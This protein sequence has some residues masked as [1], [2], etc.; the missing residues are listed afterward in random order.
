MAEAGG[1]VTW[2]FGGGLYVF[3]C[4]IKIKIYILKRNFT[5]KGRLHCSL[6]VFAPPDV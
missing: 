1:G 6:I 4:E 3:V 5:D 2:L